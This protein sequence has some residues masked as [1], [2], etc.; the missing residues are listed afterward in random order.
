MTGNRR[1]FEEAMRAGADAAWDRNWNQAIASYQQALSEF[2]NDVGALTSLG[3]AYSN[4]GRWDAA[5]GAYQRASERTPDDPVLYERIGKAL[6]HLGQKEKAA[7]AHLAAAERYL[8]QQQASHLAL[9]RWHDAVRIWPGCV[10]AHVKLLQYYQGQGQVREAVGECLILARIYNSQ[11]RMDYSIQV[12]E[13]ALKLA[14]R[15]PEVLATLDKLRYGEALPF[16]LDAGTPPAPSDEAFD[17][18][19]A[20]DGDVS[21]GILDFDIEAEPGPMEERG[22]PIDITRQ[23]ALTDLA[24]SFFEEE[25]EAPLDVARRLSKA[26]IDSLIGKA[27]D[28]QTRGK[29]EDAIQAYEQVVEAGAERQAVNFNLGLLYQEKLRFDEAIAQFERAI[30]HPEYILGSHFAMGE[31]YRARGRIDEALE[32]FVEVLKIVDLATVQ[33][34]QADD[35]IQLYES[36]ADS[37]IAKGE[38]EQA[39][40]FTNSLV[41]L[42]SD[43]GWEDKVVQARSRLDALAQEGPTLSLAEVLAIPGSEHVLESVAM[44]Q[45]YAKRG[46]YYAALEECYYALDHAPVYLPIHRQIAQLLGAMG[47]VE[48]SVAKLVVVA[49]TYYIR[50][51]VRPAMGVYQHA[52][53]LAPMDTA[54]RTKLINLLISH[55]EI[56][57]ALEH[58]LVLA[59][60]YYHLAQIDKAREIYQEALRLAPRGTPGNRWEVRILHKIGDIDMQRVDWKR[61]IESYERIRELAP[62]DERARLTLMNLYYRFNRP[63]MAIA[64]LDDLLKIYREGGKKQR[65]FTVLEDVVQERPDNIPLRTRLA[66]AYLDA[67]DVEQALVHLDKLGDL[68]IEAGRSEDAKATIRAIIALKPSNV[69]AYQ[70]LLAQLG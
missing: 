10:Q 2:P 24:E 53:R 56:D 66:Q 68:Q 6:E 54:V 34:D 50:G 38:R 9:E 43:K 19:A 63:D 17:L 65:I 18:L 5:L 25:V 30:S 35:L 57:R 27:I 64:E 52:L 1:V 3:L 40:E 55:G 42:L 36:L 39:I 14:P 47:K 37:Y 46:M 4:A 15:D 26:E 70:Q 12:C 33:R 13:H 62:D 31:C 21:A 29:I 44:A 23:K 8:S 51:S 69:E 28:F 59:D 20:M 41:E 16:E 11:G 49:D 45:E 7:D 32:H 22:S 60:S 48:E 67:G 58:R 61:A